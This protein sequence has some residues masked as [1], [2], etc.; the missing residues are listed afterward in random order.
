MLWLFVC[1][2]A[3][4]AFGAGMAW[5][6]L[7]TRPGG[8]LPEPPLLPAPPSRPFQPPRTQDA[9]DDLWVLKPGDVVVRDG[10][11]H[12]VVSVLRM[13]GGANHLLR[14]A[15]ADEPE[16]ALVC[17]DSPVPSAWW[18][19]RQLQHALGADPPE[20]VVHGG[21]R[22][23]R[24]RRLEVRSVDAPEGGSVVVQWYE[25]PDGTGLWVWRAVGGTDVLAARVVRPGGV[26]VLHS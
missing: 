14:V 24:I 9:L 7:R 12:T 13:T 23:R 15:F 26:M 21:M 4:G 3:A 17:T 18:C 11:D 22:H 20:T 19:T 16:T 5:A 25:G 8:P 10:A 6:Q 1:L 2:T